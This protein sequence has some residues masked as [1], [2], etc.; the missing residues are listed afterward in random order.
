[1]STDVLDRMIGE[2]DALSADEKRQLRDVLDESLRQDELNKLAA[3]VPSIKS[4]SG[5]L[6]LSSD[7]FAAAKAEE[8]EL[9]ERGCKI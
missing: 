1:M 7:A 6:G 4:K 3:L 5:H 2:A 8:I 9:E